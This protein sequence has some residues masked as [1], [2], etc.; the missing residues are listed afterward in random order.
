MSV[1][2]LTVYLSLIFSMMFCSSVRADRDRYYL[3]KFSLNDLVV[4]NV[5]M[6]PVGGTLYARVRDPDGRIHQ[7]FEGAYVGDKEGKVTAIKKCSVEI[8]ELYPDR[9]GGWLEKKAIL[10][11]KSCERP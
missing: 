3:E 11:V 5:L 1:T 2:K 4:T 6:A 10:T 7:V 9:D 8:I